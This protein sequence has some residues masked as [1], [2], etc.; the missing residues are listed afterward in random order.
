MYLSINWNVN[1]F[2]PFQMYI[3]NQNKSIFIE[4]L[5]KSLIY[6]LI[7]QWKCWLQHKCAL[8]TILYKQ[9]ALSLAPLLLKN[10]KSTFGT[11]TCLIQTQGTQQRVAG[12]ISSIRNP[13]VRNPATISQ[14]FHTWR[15][16]STVVDWQ[17]QLVTKKWQQK[18]KRNRECVTYLFVSV[19]SYFTTWN[20]HNN[21]FTKVLR[22]KE[23]STHHWAL[24]M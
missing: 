3:P 8:F 9:G 4:S 10:A 18:W 2:F 16:Y 17:E 12:Q 24:S 13:F 20:I 23:A 19:I 6:G 7:L 22:H 5:E 15:D 1:H 11:Q 14:P 21:I